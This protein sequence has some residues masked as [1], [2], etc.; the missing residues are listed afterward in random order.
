MTFPIWGILWR[1][2]AAC[3][4]GVRRG[5]THV[6]IF[7]S[8]WKRDVTIQFMGRALGAVV[9]FML[10]AT[11]GSGQ[12]TAEPRPLRLNVRLE[13]APALNPASIKFAPFPSGRRCA[14]T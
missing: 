4:R 13:G 2:S 5:L 1:W 6:P 14:F 9:G 11:S 12:Q 3:K 10:L 8:H 7:R